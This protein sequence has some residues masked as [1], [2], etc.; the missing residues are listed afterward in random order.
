M[1]GCDLSGDITRQGSDRDVG[2]K[3][4][5]RSV[6]GLSVICLQTWLGNNHPVTGKGFVCL[7]EAVV[8]EYGF[9]CD[10]EAGMA[11]EGS[12]SDL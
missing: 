9:A 5:Q 12:A 10:F 3:F 7:R 2:R 8:T 4:Y 11:G 6:K 1:L